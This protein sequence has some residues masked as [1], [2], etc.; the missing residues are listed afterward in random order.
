MNYI[1]LTGPQQGIW[2][3]EKFFQGTP[4]GNIGGT[5]LVNEELDFEILEKATNYFIET[6]DSIRL[7]V[8]MED[9]K[10]LQYVDKH[11]YRRLEFIDFSKRRKDEEN[12]WVAQQ[13]QKPIEMYENDLFEVILM[14]SSEGLCGGFMKIHHLV[15]DGWTF[16]LLCTQIMD[17]YSKMKNDMYFKNESPNPSYIEYILKEQEYINSSKYLKDKQFWLEKFKEK[18]E[19]VS[20]KPRDKGVRSNANRVTCI[21]DGEAAELIN[22]YCKVRS[23]SPAVLFEAA[24]GIYISRFLDV[25]EITIGTPILNRSGVKEKSTTGMYVS[26]IPME[27]NLNDLDS[28]D[29]LCKNITFEHHSVFRHQ[30][31][32]YSMLLSEIRKRHKFTHNLFDIIVSYQNAK[33]TKP[34]VDYSIKTNWYFNGHISE[35]LQIH[36]DDRDDIGVFVINYDYLI[37]IFTESEIRDL[38]KR[39]LLLLMQGISEN[40]R[41]ICDMELVDEDE[42]EMLLYDFNKTYVDYPR[43]MCIHQL[44]E[45][46]VDLMPDKIA[47]VFEK[48]ELTYRNLN[49]KANALAFILREKGVGNNDIVAIVSNRS[50][51][52]IV[53]QLA[54]LKAGGAYLPI[55]P[56]YPKERIEFLLKDS[57]CKVA[58]VHGS[59]LDCNFQIDILPIE[60][61]FI[62]QYQ[63]NIDCINRPEDTAAVIYTSGSTGLPK[64]TLL[65][66]SSIVNFCSANKF[67]Y[68]ESECIVSTTHTVF[69][70]FT[71]DTIFPVLNGIKTVI[72][73]ELEQFN[74]SYFEALIERN[75]NCTFFATP[76]K[77]KQYIINSI[78]KKFID[79]I[80]C[81]VVGGEAF[82]PEVFTMIKKCNPFAKVFNIYGPTETTVWSSYSEVKSVKITIGKPFANTQIYILDKYYHLLPIGKPG[83]IFISG[84]GVTKGYLNRPDMTKERFMDSKFCEGAI[85]FRTGD[86]AR[87]CNNGEI[88]YI[89]RKDNQ[90]KIRGLRI[91]LE[92]IEYVMNSFENLKLSIVKD[93]KDSSGKQY[94]CG[95]YLSDNELDERELRSYLLERLPKYMVPNYFMHLDSMPITGSGKVDRK[96][97]PDP[98]INNDKTHNEY[99]PPTS[100]F[101]CK[102]S[103]IAKQILKLPQVGITDDF[104]DLGGDSLS[105]IEYVAK[106]HNEGIY[107]TLQN[108]YDYPQIKSLC[109]F[110]TDG[111]REAI[112]YNVDDFNKFEPIL[113]VNKIRRFKHKNRNIGNILITGV[114]GFLGVHILDEF[115]KNEKG[116]AYCLVRGESLEQSKE[117]LK[118]MLRYYFKNEYE[119]YLDTRII[120]LQGDITDDN[121]GITECISV[122]TVF[123]CAASVKHYGSYKYFYSVNTKGT[124]NVI[125][126]CKRNS[127]ALFYV[128]T[129]SVSGDSLFDQFGFK[130]AKEEKN[131]YESSFFIEQELDNVYI[132]SKFEAE[133]LVLESILEGLEATI[134]RVGSLTNRFNDARFQPNYS[135]NAFVKRMKAIIDLGMI[136]DYLSDILVD[137]IPVD[138]CAKAVLLIAQN[139]S[140]E[141]T[142]F[143]LNSK[144]KLMELLRLFNKQ[145]IDLKIVP[146]AYFVAKLADVSSNEANKYI[147]EYLVNDMDKDMNL[148]YVVN[149]HVKND[150]TLWYLKEHGFSYPEI[151][152]DYI[153]KYIK[154]F[155]EIGFLKSV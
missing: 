35:Q 57:N 17:Y 13:M 49:F 31:Y 115:L 89:G 135:E 32:P 36:I 140:R 5:M 110:L 84:E 120:T 66:H 147:Y 77:L 3:T 59:K 73:S 39:I 16:G 125:N 47:V 103:E 78:S 105:A 42:R 137:M 95:Y 121:L 63:G 149:I 94:L 101:E 48:T 79:K 100:I 7:K 2:D 11:K 62:S 98:V 97:L 151:G 130:S 139:N 109:K 111:D 23:T 46:H 102:L 128:S 154:Y 37:D 43:Y 133:K 124:E 112:K 106:S 86:I 150:F 143:H 64:G 71:M 9:G 134:L 4:I 145:G 50:H 65:K 113:S 34:D 90:V 75:P 20:L 99:I 96:S 117:R 81:F 38:H 88:E 29:T 21:I 83:E 18:P 104:F 132:R 41:K 126:F 141:F 74:Q 93:A 148:Q 82:I 51:L 67:L 27:L 28:F 69:D 6:N 52:I 10:P 122:D 55:D 127:S 155:K 136:P 1:N 131:F 76:T 92:E 8:R 72:G 12:N 70:V 40:G 22:H 54:I 152:D 138:Q 91:E 14:K 144:S 53:A 114:T 33:I 118:D 87:W 56:S 146:S 58:L 19:L 45:K 119:H 108:V 30:R 24:M 153:Y 142:V 80:K 129:M 60:C 107:F 68:Q 123:H 44:F 15:G 25:H 116:K 26:T 85:M 61:D